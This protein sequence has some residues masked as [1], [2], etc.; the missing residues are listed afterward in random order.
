MRSDFPAPKLRIALWF[1]SFLWWIMTPFILL[2]LWRRGRK[3]P[4]YAHHVPERFGR[5]KA[6]L[7]RPVW[8]HA[9]SLGEMRSATPLIRALLADGEAVLSTHFTPAGRREAEREFATEIAEGRFA[10]VWVP[11][12][13]GFAYRR[14]LNHFAPQYGLV[15]EIEIWPRMITACRKHGTDLFMC[16]AQYPKKSYEKDKAGLGLRAALIPG[17]AGGFVKSNGQRKR[18]AETGLQNIHVTGELRFDQPIPS[19]HIAAANEHA[20]ALNRGRPTYTLTSVVE[21]EDAVYMRMIKACPEA[22]FVYVPRAP[23]RFDEVADMLKSAGINF[24]RRSVILDNALDRK[25]VV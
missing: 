15:M 13:Y 11:F 5:Y 12:E 2:Y 8:V 21:G 9:V 14:F 16:N 7:Y 4:V 23:E 22:F 3:D 20:S 10:T 19:A 1:Y 24:A 6:T 17:F 18:F 25:S